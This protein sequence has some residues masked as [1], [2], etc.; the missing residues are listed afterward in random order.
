MAAAR[1][2]AMVH[3]GAGDDPMTRQSRLEEQRPKRQAR[4]IPHDRYKVV[5]LICSPNPTYGV[6]AGDGYRARLVDD[7]ETDAGS[8]RKH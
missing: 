8:R 5:E 3:L 1:T 6:P 2:A 4:R 7:E